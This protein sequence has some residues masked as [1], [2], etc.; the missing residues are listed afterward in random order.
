MAV[1]APPETASNSELVAWSF[2]V[3][4]T[5]DV[6]PLKEQMWTADTWERFPTRTRHGADDIA[7]EFEA[8][9]RAVPDFRISIEAMAEQGDAVFVRWRITGTHSG[10]PWE[11]IAP[12]GRHMELDG[13]DHMTLRDRKL[14]SN[15]IVFD[16]L[17]FARAVGLVPVAGST[18][19]RAMKAGYAARIKV[20]D[21]LRARRV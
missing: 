16:Q 19:D 1:T 13:L 5:H 21:R 9:F 7:L 6:T 8:A 15:F 2:D 10:A 12:S 3:L 11:G 20:S 17:Q 14:V 4:N 18:A